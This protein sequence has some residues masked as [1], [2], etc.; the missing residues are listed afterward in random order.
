MLTHNEDFQNTLRG[1]I[2]PRDRIRS[3]FA[4]E[5]LEIEES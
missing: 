3:I 2:L 4:L 5:K 1:R